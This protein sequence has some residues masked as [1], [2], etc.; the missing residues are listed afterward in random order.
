MPHRRIDSKLRE[1]MRVAELLFRRSVLNLKSFFVS[2][3]DYAS[4]PGFVGFLRD[5]APK[6]DEFR[7]TT[8]GLQVCARL[9]RVDKHLDYIGLNGHDTE[10]DLIRKMYKK[11]VQ[12]LATLPIDELF[13]GTHE[14]VFKHPLRVCYASYVLDGER[15]PTRRDQLA[16]ERTVVLYGLLNCKEKID[17]PLHPYVLLQG[18]RASRRAMRA[19][20]DLYSW[21]SARA[22]SI[23]G[24]DV[25]SQWAHSILSTYG[26]AEQ[27]EM[28]CNTSLEWIHQWC[29]A[30]LS[31][32]V[33][34]APSS[35]TPQQSDFDPGGIA[36]AL[37]ILFLGRPWDVDARAA[38]RLVA[39]N[40]ALVS[41]S[42][43]NLLSTINPNATIPFGVPFF[44][45]PSGEGTFPP[46]SSGLV[47]T[48][49]VIHKLLR[50]LRSNAYPHW[51][52][53]LVRDIFE[54]RDPKLT[55][56]FELPAFLQTS[57]LEHRHKTS[58]LAAERD[59]E[60]WRNDRAPRAAEP[61]DSRADSWITVEVLLL[62]TYVREVLHEY[63][64]LRLAQRYRASRQ[65]AAPVWPGHSAN[66]GGGTGQFIDPDLGDRLS[67]ITFLTENIASKVDAAR[68]QHALH[69]IAGFLMSALWASRC[70]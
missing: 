60:G 5:S 64:H 24:L 3:D 41:H 39:S 48:A 19:I 16:Y 27:L 11:S 14:A 54:S 25:N 36:F 70:F 53:R 21:H 56:L 51:M 67:A 31:R 32:Q 69:Q 52:L 10:V 13:R 63:M 57:S 35:R 4:T 22:S 55:E 44:Y 15:D 46:S 59:I 1:Q 12:Y 40:E 34:V 23:A 61:H 18:V 50:S 68:D 45:Q 17:G 65:L 47:C 8:G 29:I 26:T 7:V 20:P 37:D 38:A 33:V 58:L 49:S 30:F 2:S 28:A 62:A 6:D 9:A 66:D 42:L 43:I